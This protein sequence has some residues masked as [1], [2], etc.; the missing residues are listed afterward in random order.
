LTLG[1]PAGTQGS[2]PRNPYLHCQPL[3]ES[4]EGVHPG[5]TTSGHSAALHPPKLP[6]IGSSFP[7]GA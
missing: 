5:S 2:P 1:R 3:N 7:P 6:G 4:W